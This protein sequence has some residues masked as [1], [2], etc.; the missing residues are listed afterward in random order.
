MPHLSLFLVSL[1]SHSQVLCNPLL[2]DLLLFVNFIF[3]ML[4][5]CV[6]ISSSLLQEF[7]EFY[8]FLQSLFQSVNLFLQ[9]EY[10]LF[11]D[12]A[13]R[14]FQWQ[15]AAVLLLHVNE[16][17]FV[18]NEKALTFQFVSS[19]SYDDVIVALSLL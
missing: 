1:S 11:E 8:I 14:I 3:N 10:F 19:V 9:S 15:G 7:N 4:H 17:F 13:R 6:E 2:L 5:F 12:G 18:G 16:E